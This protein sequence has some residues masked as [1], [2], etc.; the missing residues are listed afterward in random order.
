MSQDTLQEATTA[1]HKPSGL[2]AS[3]TTAV[4]P[5]PALAY[6][7]RDLL[8]GGGLSSA[9]SETKDDLAAALA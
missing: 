3:A 9:V 7:T 4:R 5:R 1:S 6:K 2:G 8:A